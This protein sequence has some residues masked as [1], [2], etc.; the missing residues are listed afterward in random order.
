MSTQP[1]LPI[2]LAEK[3]ESGQPFIDWL[4]RRLGGNRLAR[5]RMTAFIQEWDL[6]RDE[7]QQ[8][9]HR[10]PTVEEYS[11]RWNVSL[12]SAYRLL[13]EFRQVFGPQPPGEL[14]QLLWEGMPRL[15]VPGSPNQLGS[16]MAVDVVPARRD[17]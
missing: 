13:A 12:S 4:G 14:C 17:T 1:A 15:G 7:V 5:Q 9:Q 3:G 8:R 6:L 2:R 11:E 16:L 10:E